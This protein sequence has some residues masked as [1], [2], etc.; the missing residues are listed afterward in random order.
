[1]VHQEIQLA[2]IKGHD[3]GT[4]AHTHGGDAAT[5]VQ[6]NVQLDGDYDLSS[7]QKHIDQSAS[8]RQ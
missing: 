4:G 5:G 6:V 1:M 8:F 7:P 2:H 3:H